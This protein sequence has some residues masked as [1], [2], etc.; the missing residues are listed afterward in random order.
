[1]AIPFHAAAR[2]SGGGSTG[3]GSATVSA[4]TEP[5]DTVVV[6]GAGGVG[7]NALQGARAVGAKYIVAGDPVEW[8]LYSAKICVATHTAASAE[9]AVP[10]VREITDGLMA[11]RVVI[12]PGVVHVDLIP[13]AM[14][15]LRKGGICV[16]TGITP[17]TEP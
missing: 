9:E 7:M 12:C 10:L 3:W 5:G 4:G 16:L 14:A 2:V 6:I 15:L 17:F 8:K 13:L 1:E 11:D